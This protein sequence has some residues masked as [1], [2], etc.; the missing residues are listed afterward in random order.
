MVNFG[1]V[2]FQALI[3]A[4]V[5]IL[6]LLL[7]IM[8]FAYWP[9]KYNV[10]WKT[11]RKIVKTGRNEPCPCGSGKKYKKCCYETFNTLYRVERWFLPRK[12]M[13]ASSK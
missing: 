2:D 6:V 8:V 13:A 1:M 11:R 9:E 4:Y 5:F 7:P 10:L 3:W 12:K